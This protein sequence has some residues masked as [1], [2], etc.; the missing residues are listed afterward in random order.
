M[1]TDEKTATCAE[2][3]GRMVFGRSVR[4]RRTPGQL[5]SQSN[6]WPAARMANAGPMGCSEAPDFKD[7]VKRVG[8]L[9]LLIA[10]FSILFFLVPSG[11][12]QEWRATADN[13]KP[14]DCDWTSMPPGDKHCHYVSRINRFNDKQG[15]EHVV[16]GWYRVND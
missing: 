16:A 14:R 7:R 11:T 6:L 13:P 3:G 8:F 12:F 9:I 2:C 10:A 4:K 15:V 1:V 5:S